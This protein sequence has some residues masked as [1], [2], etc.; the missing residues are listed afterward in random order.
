MKKGDLVNVY[1]PRDRVSVGLGI[2]LEMTRTD[3]RPYYKFLWK[4]RVAEFDRPY[5]EFEVLSS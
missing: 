2:F 5:W 3:G 1:D 4:G